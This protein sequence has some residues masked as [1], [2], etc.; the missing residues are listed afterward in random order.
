MRIL[1]NAKQAVSLFN[2]LLRRLFEIE[3]T[4]C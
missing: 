1:R 2:R 3:K 4:G